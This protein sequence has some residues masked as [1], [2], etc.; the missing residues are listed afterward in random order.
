M[1]GI[2]TV[3]AYKMRIALLESR[4]GRDNKRVIAKLYRK[5]RALERNM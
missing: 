1:F 5:I 4:T 2:H 3:E